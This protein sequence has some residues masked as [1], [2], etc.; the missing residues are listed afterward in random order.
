MSKQSKWEYLKSIH[1]RYRHVLSTN[2]LVRFLTPGILTVIPGVSHAADLRNRS[3]FI[4]YLPQG[5][6]GE[7]V[8]GGDGEINKRLWSDPQD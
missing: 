2:R 1:Q 7:D 3:C 6:V 5:Q 8:G 4:L